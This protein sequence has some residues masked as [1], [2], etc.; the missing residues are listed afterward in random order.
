MQ[1]ESKGKV[2][3]SGI[4]GRHGNAAMLVSE[5]DGT[6]VRESNRLASAAMEAVGRPVAQELSVK[7]DADISVDFS[8]MRSSSDLQTRARSFKTLVEGGKTVEEATVLSGLM[9]PED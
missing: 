9:L 7:L 3:D 5:S 1:S 8:A 2:A 6:M 4:I